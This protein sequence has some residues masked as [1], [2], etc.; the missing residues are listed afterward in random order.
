MKKENKRLKI[1]RVKTAGMLL[2]HQIIGVRAKR[3]EN[4][5]NYFE[6]FRKLTE[7]FN[8]ESPLRLRFASFLF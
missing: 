6:N 7:I 5:N 2:R 8:S 4:M 1:Q 3:S